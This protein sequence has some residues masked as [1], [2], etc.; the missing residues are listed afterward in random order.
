[1]PYLFVGRPRDPR[2]GFIA[3]YLGA[4]MTSWPPPPELDA[5]CDRA[6]LEELDEAMWWMDLLRK[7]RSRRDWRARGYRPRRGVEPFATLY[8][9]SW[10]PDRETHR[11]R[12]GDPVRDYYMPDQV[13]KAYRIDPR[14]LEL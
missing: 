1:V 10:D 4:Y 12:V 9:G 5:A 8:S 7:A 3:Y 6:S 14:L 2:P 13:E 11:Q